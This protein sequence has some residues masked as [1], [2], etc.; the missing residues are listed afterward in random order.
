MRKPDGPTAGAGG[1]R[2]LVHPGRRGARGAAPADARRAALPSDTRAGLTYLFQR[3]TGDDPFRRT[4]ER[5]S[6]GAALVRDRLD[7]ETG[8]TRVFSP[9]AARSWT[10]DGWVTAARRRPAHRCPRDCSSRPGRSRAGPASARRARSTAPSSRGSARGSTAAHA[11][12]SWTTERDETVTTLTL[13]PVPGVRR[14]TQVRLNDSPPVAVAADGTRAA[15]AADPRARVPARDPARRVPARHAGNDAAAAR[16]RDR[17]GGT[18]GPTVASR[19][20]ARSTPRLL[21]GRQRSAT[22]SCGGG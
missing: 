15:P 4:H 1:I 22:R 21:R 17:R 20:P 7:G 12:L 13:D 2:E 9:P 19:A 8:I 14:P 3:T 5:G 18:A 10:L 6:A 16:R 11:W